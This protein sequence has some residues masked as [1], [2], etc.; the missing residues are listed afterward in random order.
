[1]NQKR[2]KIAVLASGT[3]TNFRAIAEACRG[4]RFPAEVACLISDN[5]EAKAL[6]IAEEFGV[7]YHL[8]VGGEKRGHLPKESEEE[9]VS[10]CR[11]AGVDLVALAGFMR[12]LKGPLLDAY[13]GRIL[14]IHPS[15]LP[16]FKGL[17]AQEQAFDYGVK[18]SGC[19][20]HFVDR[21]V[22]GGPIIIQAAVPVEEGDDADTLAAR[23]LKE[24]HR[25]YAKAI[26]LFAMGRLKIEGRKVEVMDTPPSG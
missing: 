11:G 10:I 19:T 5:P 24:E 7:P 22:D 2:C 9:I 18:V 13:D 26:E 21:S 3:G 12:I 6:S 15:L 23:I 25:I 17:H 20:V 16:S 1:M 4:E 14:N 8:I